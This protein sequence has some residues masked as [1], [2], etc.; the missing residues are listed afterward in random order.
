M[1]IHCK[2]AETVDVP[3]VTDTNE[4][5]NEVQPFSLNKPKRRMLPKTPVCCDMEG[6]FRSEN[7]IANFIDCHDKI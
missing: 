2:I 5:D 7:Q 1:S 6:G 3:N 4:T